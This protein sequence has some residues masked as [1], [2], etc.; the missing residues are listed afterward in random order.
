LESKIYTSCY[1]TAIIW[2]YNYYNNY[3]L[4]SQLTALAV[5]FLT[6]TCILDIAV[7]AGVWC[8]TREVGSTSTD[9]A[10]VG[11]VGARC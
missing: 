3:R 11:A 6:A 1:P 4:Y 5:L 9:R 8:V 10:T 7:R 2:Y